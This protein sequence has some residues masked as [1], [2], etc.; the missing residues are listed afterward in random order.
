MRKSVLITSIVILLCFVVWGAC[1]L[2]SPRSAMLDTQR[3]LV[4]VRNTG[5]IGEIT[6]K[7]I[8]KKIVTIVIK[9]ERGGLEQEIIQPYTYSLEFFTLDTGYGPLLCYDDM[10]ICRFAQDTLGH[11][12]EVPGE[13][14]KWIEKGLTY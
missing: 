9:N 14:F 8:I 6:D 5:Q 2:F 11:Y 7:A 1:K 3:I 13:F 4:T 10:G 12:I